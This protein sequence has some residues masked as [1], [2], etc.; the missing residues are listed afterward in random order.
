MFYG[1]VTKVR[2]ICIAMASG[3]HG[4]R[5]AGRTLLRNLL[6]KNTLQLMGRLYNA[7]LNRHSMWQ[8]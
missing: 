3:G 1:Y 6:V 2:H 5:T 7:M 8:L 4:S